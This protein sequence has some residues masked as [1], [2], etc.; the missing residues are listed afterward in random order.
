ME[1]EF[2]K[3]YHQSSKDHSKGH[4]PISL[5][6]GEWPDEWRTT[7]YKAYPRLPKIILED[8]VFSAD[9]AKTIKN[10][11]S[12]RDF[13]LKPLI[14]T[15]ISTILRYSCGNIGSMGNG[16]QR[17]AQPSGGAR[18]PIEV[19]PLI[20][21]SSE[22]SRAG[23]YHYN[24]KDHALDLLWRYEFTASELDN[25]FTYS[26]VKNVSMIVV[27][28]AVFARTQN[29]YGERGYRYAMIEAGH[30]GQNIYLV[31]ESLNMKCCALGVPRENIIHPLLRIDGEEEIVFYAVAIGN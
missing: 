14:L 2:A 27:M 6:P 21:C 19:Y 29:K 23:L 11:H 18:F 1:Y 5:D 3:L 30:I 22:E 10:R 20:V 8:A 4:V 12:S 17:R 13:H 28:T 31:A 25:L 16:R 24:V 9:L 7:Y 15:E 26:W